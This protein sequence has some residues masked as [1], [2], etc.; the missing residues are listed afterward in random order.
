MKTLLESNNLVISDIYIKSPT[1]GEITTR[2]NSERQ[3]KQRKA[4]A[5]LGEGCGGLDGS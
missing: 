1:T 3:K 5:I 2:K 4:K